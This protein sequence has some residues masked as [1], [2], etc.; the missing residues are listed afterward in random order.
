MSSLVVIVVLE[1]LP[2]ILQFVI[3]FVHKKKVTLFS[4]FYAF[5]F[6]H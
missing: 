3:F 1:K 5:I 4:F 6:I 2:Y